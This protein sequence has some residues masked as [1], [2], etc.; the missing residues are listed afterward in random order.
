MANAIKTEIIMNGTRSY[1]VHFS[2]ASDGS[3]ETNTAVTSG[4]GKKA[5]LH[6][7]RGTNNAASTARVKLN[8]TDT[9][10]TPLVGLPQGRIDFYACEYLGIPNPNNTGVT[11]E[12]DIT[13]TGLAS[14][15]LI[16]FVAH[17]KI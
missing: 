14:G 6:S 16:E 13:T 10:H 9:G 2:L 12:V 7:I 15:D 8:W 11:G 17:F 3:N 5:H 4:L 1:I